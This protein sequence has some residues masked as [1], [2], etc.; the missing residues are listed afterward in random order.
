M[1]DFEFVSTPLYVTLFL[2]LCV[3]D[4]EKKTIFKHCLLHRIR[5]FLVDTYINLIAKINQFYMSE[6]ILLYFNL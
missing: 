1:R 2:H 3:P 6:A 5:A 4:L